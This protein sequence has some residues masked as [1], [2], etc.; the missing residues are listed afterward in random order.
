MCGH[1]RVEELA[2]A[3]DHGVNLTTASAEMGIVVES[4]PQIVDGL[5]AGLRTRVD[6]DTDFGLFE[7]SDAGRHQATKT[8]YLEHLADSIEQPAVR[9]N[10][11]LV[12]RLD[13]ED[14]LDR[15]EVVRVVAMGDH[16]LWGGID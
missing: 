6:E 16:Q 14:N 8:S 3:L 11:L 1:E 10:L 12:L 9:V 4:L 13:D 5:A 15:D 2:T 7:G